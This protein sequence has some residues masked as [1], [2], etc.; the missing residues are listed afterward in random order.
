[1]TDYSIV[2]DF[3]GRPY[4][5]QNGEELQ[6]SPGRKTPVNAKAYT[7][8]STLAGTLDDKSGLIDWSSA[9]AMMGIVKSKALYAQL[10]HLVSAHEDPWAV[11]AAKKPLKELVERARSLGGADDASGMGTA[12]HGLCEVLDGGEKPQYT[13][14]ELGPWIAARQA[15]LE[16]FDPV[17]IE[18]FIVN[19]GVEAAG[20]PDRY[21]LHKP[22]GT[23]YAADDK[24]GSSEPDFPLKVTI[25]VA[26]ASRGVLYDQETGKRTPIKCDQSRGLLIHTPIR[27]DEPRCELYWLD[28]DKGWELAQ[29]SAKVRD[30]RKISKLVKA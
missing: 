22:T 5:T 29:L 24:T 28:L 20:N 8:I 9:R 19:D 10:A 12:F 1:M 13:P 16:D 11:P 14:R 6:Y 23:V 30:A 21:L 4:V 18:P 27:E 3:W 7:R 17:L 2:R 15:R 25:Q 26:I